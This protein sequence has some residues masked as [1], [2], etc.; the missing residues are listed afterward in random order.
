MDFSEYGIPSHEWREFEKANPEPIW[1]PQPEAR[2]QI[3]NDTNQMWESV[4]KSLMSQCNL[5]ELVEF[6]DHQVDMRDNQ[7]IFVRCYRPRSE[8]TAPKLLPALV[9]FH[10][11]GYIFGNLETHHYMLAKQSHALGMVVVHVNYRHLPQCSGMTPWYDSIDGFEWVMDHRETLR[12]DPTKVI[13]SGVSSGG[14]LAAAVVQHDLRRSRET[15]SPPRIKGQIL[16]IP[17]LVQGCNFPFELFADKSKTSLVQCQN[18]PILPKE[19]YDFFMD[20]LNDGNSDMSD[21]LWNPGLAPADELGSMPQTAFLISGADMLRDEGLMYASNLKNH[22]VRTKVHIF[23]G[24]PHGFQ[25]HPELQSYKRWED[26]M[27]ECIRW[28]LVDEGG[29]FIEIPPERSLVSSV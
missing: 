12:I 28:T 19:R 6:R 7:S 2:E 9:F 21:P 27:S 4:S 3:Q 16:A 25:G 5:N 20:P 23:S 11:G 26:V 14:N 8:R 18:M 17:H 13:V 10:G 24:L 15:N 1:E 22:G 29:W